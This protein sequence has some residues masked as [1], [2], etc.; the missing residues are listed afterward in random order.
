MFLWKPEGCWSRRSSANSATSAA[1]T[2]VRGNSPGGRLRS[3]SSTGDQSRR[4][5]NRVS[6]P[7]Q[8]VPAGDVSAG[9]NVSSPPGNAM[10]CRS[11][12]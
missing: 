5:A 7:G 3:R 1:A 9:A 6:C 8:T 4:M 11:A 2:A 12:P 10:T